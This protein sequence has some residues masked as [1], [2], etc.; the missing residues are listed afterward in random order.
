MKITL[1]TF[2]T[3][4]L[5]LMSFSQDVIHMKDNSENIGTVIEIAQSGV[6]YSP[7]GYPKTVSKIIPIDKIYMIV[8]ENG[9]T[10]KLTEY[11]SSNTNTTSNKSVS[12]TNNSIEET[13]YESSFFKHKNDHNITLATGYGNSYGGIGLRFQYRTG[14][15]MGVGFHGG[16]GL[17][18]A[19]GDVHIFPSAG[20]KW[21][22]YKG[23]YLNGQFGA[24]GVEEDY[25]GYYAYDESEEILWGPSFMTGVDW[26]W[27]SKIGIGFNAGVGASLDIEN[28]DLWPAIDLG[29]LLRF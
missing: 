11:R 29:F 25:S 19:L 6:T 5:P 1:T 18:P 8:F 12:T 3:L 20:V 22:F 28:S 23:I 2:L 26:V 21:F 15:I 14:D 27:G 10:D 24:F 13:K 17:F 4:L 9:K 7:D 16:L